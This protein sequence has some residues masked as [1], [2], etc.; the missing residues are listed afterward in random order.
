MG[1]LS[2]PVKEG[3]LIVDRAGIC[4]VLGDRALWIRH[5][6]LTNY[7]QTAF[8]RVIIIRGIAYE[9]FKF[10]LVSDGY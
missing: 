4:R 9:A 1:P 7:I 3:S 2:D 8:S 5:V 6:R 10:V